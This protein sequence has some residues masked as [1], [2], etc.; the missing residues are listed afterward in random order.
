METTTPTLERLADLYLELTT[1]VE[2]LEAGRADWPTVLTLT[3][4]V[5]ELE[6]RVE[7]LTRRVWRRHYAPRAIA[8]ALRAL[9]ATI[10]GTDTR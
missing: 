9:A 10:D 4:R 2:R 6:P 3:H 7:A 5:A 1:R 8:R